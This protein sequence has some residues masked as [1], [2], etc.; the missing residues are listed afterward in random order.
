M[1]I[2]Y[3]SQFRMRISQMRKEWQLSDTTMCHIKSKYISDFADFEHAGMIFRFGLLY[4]Y[5]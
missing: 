1:I 3:R 5:G 2:D 4:K